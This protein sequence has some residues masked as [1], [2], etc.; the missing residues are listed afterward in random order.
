M[1]MAHGGIVL[2]G[3][4]VLLVKCLEALIGSL[5]TAA[6][7]ALSLKTTFYFYLILY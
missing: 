4:I 7:S 2:Y 3:V 1:P 5:E 6:V